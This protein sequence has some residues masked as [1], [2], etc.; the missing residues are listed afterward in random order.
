MFRICSCLGILMSLRSHEERQE[1]R[2]CHVSLAR[3]KMENSPAGSDRPP[4]CHRA[5]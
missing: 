5:A 1:P 3:I 2:V 4:A